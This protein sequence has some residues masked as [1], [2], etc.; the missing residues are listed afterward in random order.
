MQPRDALRAATTMLAM[1][2]LAT[3]GPQYETFSA[4]TPPE[5]DAGRQCLAQCQAARQLCRQSSSLQVQQ[6]RLGAQQEA[7]TENLRRSTEYQI[8][9]QRYQAGLRSE[10]PDAPETVSPSYWT[11]DS[12]TDALEKQCTGDYD[13]CYQSCGGTVTYSTQCVAN[14]Q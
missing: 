7:Q 9:L 10:P 6:C 3:C 13:L 2:A 8:K 12:Q 4:Y 11:C 5:S 14:C 1:A